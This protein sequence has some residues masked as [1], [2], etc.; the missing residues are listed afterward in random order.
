MSILLAGPCS[1][2]HFYLYE[3]AVKMT[4]VFLA[5]RNSQDLAKH[6]TANV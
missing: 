3:D 6:V 5:L 2:A 1:V 4:L